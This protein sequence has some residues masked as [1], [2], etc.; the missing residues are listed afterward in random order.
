MQTKLLHALTHSHKHFD[1]VNTT[2]IMI[3][4]S[5]IVGHDW[6]VQMET[7]T[8]VCKVEWLIIVREIRINS[9]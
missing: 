2:T 5:G 7:R 3:A 6:E 9:K 4:K 1:E 8:I